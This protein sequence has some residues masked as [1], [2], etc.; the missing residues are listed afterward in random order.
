MAKASATIVPRTY[1]LN[2]HHELPT[3]EKPGGGRAAQYENID[4]AVK[5]KQLSKS[6]SGVRKLL[7][8]SGDPLSGRQYFLLAA[9]EPKL[10]KKSSDKKKAPNGTI[11]EVTD[12]RSD[13]PR[14]FG[15]LGLDLIDVTD[16]G[17]AIIHATAERI[18][19]IL[20]RTENLNQL[21]SRDRARWA[22]LKQFEQI[23]L[24][25]RIDGRWLSEI[26][27]ST[28][29][30]DAVI[31]LQPLLTR[32]ESEDVL[33]GLTTALTSEKGSRLTGT[34]QDYSGRSWFRGKLSPKAIKQIA[35][36]FF[37]VQSI[38][39]P[40]Y[41]TAAIEKGSSAAS[42]RMHDGTKHVPDVA[43]LPT[44]AL[45]DTGVAANHPRLA[46]YQ[47]GTPLVAPNATGGGSHATYVA[48]RI[49][50][51]DVTYDDV[52]SENFVAECRFLS[53]NVSEYPDRIDDKSVLPMLATLRAAYPDVR[54]YNLSFSNR[55]RCRSVNHCMMKGWFEA[56]Y[57][58]IPRLRCQDQ[59][60]T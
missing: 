42:K 27:R 5:G 26:S 51:G 35:E 52:D 43:S 37:S 53:A 54:V 34:G 4:W 40:L 28:D 19:L 39:D 10:T 44:V 57:L 14:V 59:C 24:E 41:S 25:L 23:P 2:E 8:E 7:S 13:H 56:G 32:V 50:F 55:A 49:V 11:Q 47:R 17:R 9:P 1:Y 30:I 3:E 22:T 18:D 38:H 46:V 33:R 12:F 6:L 58:K 36:G 15:R 31:E 20:H 45:L 29:L 16:D 21:N 60:V 48:S